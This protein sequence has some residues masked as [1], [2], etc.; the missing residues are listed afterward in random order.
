M[1]PKSWN[2]FSEKIMRKQKILSR[3]AREPRR[4]EFKV[5]PLARRCVQQVVE[6]PLQRVECS[7]ARGRQQ[8]LPVVIVLRCTLFGLD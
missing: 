6:F 3:F 8:T 2:R 4:S 5:S 1:I 7:A